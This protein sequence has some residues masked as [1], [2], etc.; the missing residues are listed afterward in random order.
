M[1]PLGRSRGRRQGGE[2]PP[3]ELPKICHG[4]AREDDEEARCS[5]HLP[6]ES[7]P[8]PARM[9]T[10]HRRPLCERKGVGRG[11]TVVRRRG[12]WSAAEGAA[13]GVEGEDLK[14]HLGP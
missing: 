4:C 9:R 14:V 10:R 11:E 6:T 5:P 7:A 13:T 3:T 2:V 8:A 1:V 12:R